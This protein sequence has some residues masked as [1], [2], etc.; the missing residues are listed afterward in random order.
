MLKDAAYAEGEE[1]GPL[2]KIHAAAGSGTRSLAVVSRTTT[3]VWTIVTWG[4]TFR[5]RLRRTAVTQFCRARLRHQCGTDRLNTWMI[6]GRVI[7]S[8]SGHAAR[9]LTAVTLALN[10]GVALTH[11]RADSGR[12]NDP[13]Q[14]CSQEN[15]RSWDS[16]GHFRETVS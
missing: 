1:G 2:S 4:T 10:S 12:S 8:P 7:M 15:Y 3:P 16:S 9:R 11:E 6:H 14:Q 13:G 5:E